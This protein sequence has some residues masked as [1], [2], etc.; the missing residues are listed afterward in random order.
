MES[1]YA[2]D[3]GGYFSGH[4]ANL[5]CSLTYIGLYLYHGVWS[6]C[7][8]FPSHDV[9]KLIRQQSG[10]ANSDWREVSMRMTINPVIDRMLIYEVIHIDRERSIDGTTQELNR[11]A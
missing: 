2:F 3:A 9:A 5:V 10:S 7:L 8:M 6:K 4:F 11:R 1:R